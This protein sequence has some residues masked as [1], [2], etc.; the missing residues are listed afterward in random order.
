MTALVQQLA[1]QTMARVPLFPTEPIGPGARWRTDLDLTMSGMNITVTQ[2]VT[3][4]KI[5]ADTVDLDNAMVLALGAAGFVMP[6]MPPGV[7]PQVTTFVG[8]G[9][10]ATHIDLL[11][12]V[13]TGTVTMDIDLA[14]QVSVPDQPPLA[15]A[16]KVNQSTEM[17]PAQSTPP[18]GG[19]SSR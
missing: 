1:D 9:S 18:R 11:T 14:M 13:P 17:R 15:M 16:M 7:S 5:G 4:R 6:G 10:G 2:T 12:L 19:P 3:A 8:G